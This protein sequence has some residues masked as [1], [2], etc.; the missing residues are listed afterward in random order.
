M[1]RAR[2]LKAEGPR[3]RDLPA[4]AVCSRADRSAQA[5]DRARGLLLGGL[6]WGGSD[7]LFL[8]LSERSTRLVPD[9]FTLFP[10]PLLSGARPSGFEAEKLPDGSPDLYFRGF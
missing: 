1:T 2:A 3:R 10:S 9:F 8:R 4:R 6:E 7:D 5:G